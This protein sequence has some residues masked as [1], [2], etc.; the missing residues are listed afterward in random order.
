MI[1]VIKAD[2]TSEAFSDVKVLDSIKRARIPQHLQ[3]E[4]LT[5]I[6]AKVYNNMPTS[7]IYGY[8]L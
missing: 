8:I 3:K 6:K 5:Q 4:V 1:S 2:G 7:E